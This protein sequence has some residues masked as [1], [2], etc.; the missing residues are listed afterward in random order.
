MAWYPLVID[1]SGYEWIEAVADDPGVYRVQASP[2]MLGDPEWRGGLAANIPLDSIHFSNGRVTIFDGLFSFSDP[3]TEMQSGG[4]NFISAGEVGAYTAY[5]GPDDMEEWSEGS[6]ANFGLDRQLYN[7]KLNTLP[8]WSPGAEI[9]VIVMEDDWQDYA[10]QFT[11]SPFTGDVS[12]ATSV[13][14]TFSIVLVAVSGSENSANDW[15]N[16]SVEQ[17]FYIRLEVDAPMDGGGGG[18]GGGGYRQVTESEINWAAAGDGFS[19]AGNGRVQLQIGAWQDSEL[20]FTSAMNVRLTVESADWQI[21]NPEWDGATVN[22]GGY[23]EVFSYADGAP[24]VAIENTSRVDDQIYMPD[25]SYSWEGEA[26]AGPLLAEAIYF[27]QPYIQRP[28]F[29]ASIGEAGGTG[30]ITMLLEVVDSGGGGEEPPAEGACFWTDKVRVTETCGNAP[31]PPPAQQADAILYVNNVWDE[32]Q[33]ATVAWRDGDPLLDPEDPEDLASMPDPR[34]TYAPVPVLGDSV[35]WTSDNL[36]NATFGNNRQQLPNGSIYYDSVNRVLRT[37]GEITFQGADSSGSS[38]Y[39][40]IVSPHN[41]GVAEVNWALD[42]Y[43]NL[44]PAQKYPAWAVNFCTFLPPRRGNSWSRTVVTIRKLTTNVSGGSTITMYAGFGNE[45]GDIPMTVTAETVH[46]ATFKETEYLGQNSIAASPYPEGVESSERADLSGVFPGGACRPW[47]ANSSVTMDI[48]LSIQTIP[49]PAGILAGRIG[50]LEVFSGIED[51][52][53]IGLD[54]LPPAGTGRVVP[55]MSLPVYWDDDYSGYGGN[56]LIG[57][58]APYLAFRPIFDGEVSYPNLSGGDVAVGTLYDSN[59][60]EV[61]R[62]AIV[63]RDGGGA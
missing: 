40:G 35:Q 49:A 23:I 27:D 39:Y 56:W 4:T 36:Y 50:S 18:G 32:V 15:V 42:V 12:W 19:W 33:L 6:S 2:D 48:D 1:V 41:Y 16:E 52:D 17:S 25:S 26:T 44:A 43:P 63:I 45:L 38:G 11:Y 21:D 20:P 55:V 14:H 59:N 37:N 28:N 13:E 46:T 3:F 22:S 47:S 60:N 34:T 53:S 31:P 54:N 30:Q 8:F 5:F 29:G 58:N 7:E 51:L 9:P 61:C 10:G 62:I 57:V 24:Y